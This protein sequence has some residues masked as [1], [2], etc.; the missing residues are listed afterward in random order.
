MED[1]SANSQLESVRLLTE[2][3]QHQAD[4]WAERVQTAEGRAAAVATAA[5]ALGTLIV[6]QA[7]ALREH[8]T[9]ATIAFG[10]LL[11]AVAVTRGR[12]G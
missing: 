9:S 11:G 5:V 4:G 12:G 8:E 7:D 2:M 3:W 10:L 1:A 6:S